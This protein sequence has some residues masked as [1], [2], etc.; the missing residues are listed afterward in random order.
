M[1]TNYQPTHPYDGNPYQNG[2]EQQAPYGDYRHYNADDNNSL[3]KNDG[4][5]DHTNYRDFTGN[6]VTME[7][8]ENYLMEKAVGAPLIAN[9]TSLCIISPALLVVLGGLS[10]NIGFRISEGLA[11]ALGCTV[12]FG[13]VAV[14]VFMFITGGIRM[15][16]A[17]RFEKMVFEMDDNVVAML[18]NRSRD[19]EMTFARGLAVGVV[20]CIMSVVPLVVL[21]AL[22][23][24]DWVCAAAVALLLVLVA[25]G[26]NMI[27]RVA[28]VKSSFDALLQEG[29]YTREEK[30][31]KERMDAVSGLYWCVITA[32]YL[33][34]SFWSG[35]WGTTWII[36]PV[37]A[38][39]H[40]VISGI[41]RLFVGGSRC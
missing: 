41:I 37:A 4:Y 2:A 8:A 3:P 17:S 15:S 6:R 39:A 10:E 20:L 31:V 27:I 19:Y 36:W 16:H 18:L 14:A 28:I 13:L 5:N 1:N 7:E 11:A 30:H 33:G 21:A 38:L 35:H 22:G 29:E 34:W 25:I 9:A 24:P 12:L 23:A 32:V 40:G 26:V